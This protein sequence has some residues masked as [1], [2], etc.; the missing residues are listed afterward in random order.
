MP[1]NIPLLDG[2][3]GV[4]FA[5][6]IARQ[7]THEQF[8]F[9]IVVTTIVPPDA[10]TH[11]ADAT[12]ILQSEL[13][14]DEMRPTAEGAFAMS[15]IEALLLRRVTTHAAKRV[16]EKKHFRRIDHSQLTRQGSDAVGR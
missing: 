11:Q 8:R 12:G 7:E 16:L 6:V 13:R 1:R 15:F 10:D 4:G 2:E 14:R 3:G 9:P 5:T